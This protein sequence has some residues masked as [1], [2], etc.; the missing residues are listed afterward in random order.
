MHAVEYRTT[1]FPEIS[2]IRPHWQQLN[3]HHHAKSSASRFRSHYELMT[4][5]DRLSHFRRCH[6]SSDLRIDP[7]LDTET[8]RYSG[9]A[10]VH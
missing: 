7:A 5:E 2:L 8:G 9:I 4:F 3:A 1:G 6:E 10:S